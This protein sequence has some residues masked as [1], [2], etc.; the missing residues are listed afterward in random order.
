MS[1]KPNLSHIPIFSRQ[2]VTTLRS[3]NG[4]Q[5][6]NKSSS[7]SSQ[8]QVKQSM[9]KSRQRQLVI[10]ESDDSDESNNNSSDENDEPFQPLKRFLAAYSLEEHF[11]LLLQH[12][13][14]LETLVLLTD[15]DLKFINLPL[16]HYRR[17][18]VAIQERKNALSNPG[19]IIDSRL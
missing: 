15:E 13:I 6:S 5:T 16:G 18:S 3:Q 14:D 11:E 9:K 12:Q 1:Y 10:S 8:N 4:D 2:S 7:D 17:L 19:A